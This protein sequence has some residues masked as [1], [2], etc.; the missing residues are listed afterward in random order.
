MSQPARLDANYRIVGP[1]P[2]AREELPL[3]IRVA[4]RNTGTAT[5]SSRDAIRRSD[6]G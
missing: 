2:A 5:W 6:L 3:L 4:V 1:L